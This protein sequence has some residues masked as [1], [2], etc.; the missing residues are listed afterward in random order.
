[1]QWHL[2]PVGLPPRT[3]LAL[4]GG[5]VGKV[6]SGQSERT[7]DDGHRFCVVLELTGL[8][9]GGVHGGGDGAADRRREPAAVP[10][11]ALDVAVG[12]QVNERKDLRV[13][14]RHQVREG[15]LVLGTGLGERG[16]RLSTGT[17]R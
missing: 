3:P 11:D 16:L 10:H 15:P 8:G 1:M 17:M 9:D 12:A 14:V 6:V 5:S 2:G 4:A 13:D 7:G